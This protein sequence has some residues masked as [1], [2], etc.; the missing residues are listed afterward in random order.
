[1][2][3]LKPKNM[4]Y[5]SIV[6]QL[7]TFA[8]VLLWMFS[9]SVA[10]QTLQQ[11]S[12]MKKQEIRFIPE[13]FNQIELGYLSNSQ[14]PCSPMYPNDAT[15]DLWNEIII[16]APEKI[17]IPN[18][19]LKTG[20]KPTL[21]VC[22]AMVITA[23]RGYKHAQL[24]DEVLH[25]RNTESNKW[26][27]GQIFDETLLDGNPIVPSPVE[28]DWEKEL[29]K[30]IKDAQKYTEDELDEGRA[31]GTYRNIDLL[32]YVDISLEQG[33]YEIYFSTKGLESNKVQVEIVFEE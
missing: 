33:I 10:C 12:S 25:I 4:P 8:P 16:K 6:Q 30:R 21:P 9:T 19:C 17:M 2:V 27:T 1:M 22:V 18:T 23:R 29:Q 32:K 5:K 28:D 11:N 31:S 20:I 26:I 24:S 13:T 3:F 15:D 14:T 7:R